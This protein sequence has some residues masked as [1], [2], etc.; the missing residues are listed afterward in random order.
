M[1]SDADCGIQDQHVD[2]QKPAQLLLGFGKRTVG[3]RGFLLAHPHGRSG[4]DRMERR[5]R[6][7]L[8]EL[9]EWSIGHRF[10]RKR[11]PFASGQRI[12]NCLVD[13]DKAEV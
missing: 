1:G 3:G 5:G 6:Q 9:L 13:R 10:L 2:H 12:E 4:F 7:Q 11:D 8:V